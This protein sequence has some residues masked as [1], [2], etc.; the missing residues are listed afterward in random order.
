MGA[1]MKRKR[2]R[3]FG[4][5]ALEKGFITE[6]LLSK[7]LS[8]QSEARA[9]GRAQKPIGE[10]LLELGYMSMDQVIAVLDELTSAQYPHVLR[11]V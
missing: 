5:I 9:H 7:A 6:D 4:E 2:P 8:E 3:R 1:T 10:V 11:A